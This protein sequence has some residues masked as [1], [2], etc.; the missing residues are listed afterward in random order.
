MR[1][2]SCSKIEYEKNDVVVYKYKY[3]NIYTTDMTCVLYECLK[4]Q[5]V[6]GCLMCTC[7]YTY[8]IMYFKN[9]SSSMCV[10]AYYRGK[11]NLEKIFCCCWWLQDTI[12]AIIIALKCGN[13]VGSNEQCL[14][15]RIGSN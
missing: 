2:S 14:V 9:F 11:K 3:K 1:L 15:V 12:D 10:C 7:L 5:R 13:V 8:M 6:S 4:K